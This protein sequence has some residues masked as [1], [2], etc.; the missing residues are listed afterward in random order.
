MP[1]AGAVKKL[2][3]LAAECL[4]ADCWA[5]V[6]AP[7]GSIVERRTYASGLERWLSFESLE[8]RGRMWEE[9]NW[10]SATS[11]SIYVVNPAAGS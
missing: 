4:P 5:Y 8:E 6:D 9:G 10:D 7:D 2:R 1:S 11:L 3:A